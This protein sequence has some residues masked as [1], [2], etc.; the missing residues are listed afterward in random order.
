MRAH[1]TQDHTIVAM[2]IVITCAVDMEV[3]A[4]EQAARIHVELSHLEGSEELA[5]P[6][7]PIT[8]VE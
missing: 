7:K 8:S 2:P 1:I 4:V 3:R 5:R 6:L